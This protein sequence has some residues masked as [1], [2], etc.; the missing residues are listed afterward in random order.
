MNLTTND[1]LTEIF[2]ILTIFIYQVGLSLFR[3]SNFCEWHCEKYRN[4]TWFTGVEILRKGK[5]SAQ[6]ARNYAKSVPFRKISTP[7]NQVKLRYFLQ[8]DVFKVRSHLVLWSDLNQ[9]SEEETGSSFV[10]APILEK[11]CS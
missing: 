9:N 6:F 3:S 7:G 5:V 11:E 1:M 10:F 8:C 4:F 2:A